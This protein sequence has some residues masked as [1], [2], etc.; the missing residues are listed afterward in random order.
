MRRALHG[1]EGSLEVLVRP[2][3]QV[4][5]VTVSVDELPREVLRDEA[6]VALPVGGVAPGDVVP[7]ELGV[8]ILHLVHESALL[9]IRAYELH[10]IV[11]HAQA[12]VASEVA[13]LIRW[14][15]VDGFGIQIH[16]VPPVCVGVGEF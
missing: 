15:A 4:G 14:K 3:P 2:V 10:G 11:A 6:V 5:R 9:A 7:V 8:R 16:E 13:D 1:G 12:E